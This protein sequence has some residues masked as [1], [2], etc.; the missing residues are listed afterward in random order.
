[1]R[2][3]ALEPELVKAITVPR[4]LWAAMP[5]LVKQSLPEPVVAPLEQVVILATIW[6]AMQATPE[7]VGK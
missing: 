2:L 3:Q 4:Q 5:L 6:V 1:M 7:S